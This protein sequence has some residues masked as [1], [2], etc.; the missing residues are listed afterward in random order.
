MKYAPRKVFII[1]NGEYVE[2][3]YEEFKSR[4]ETDESYEDKLFLPVQGCL[5]ETDR[6]HYQEFYQ[7]KEH[8][9]YL[10]KL[11]K[12]N[13]LLSIDAFD[14]E[15]DNGTDYIQDYQEDVADTVSMSLMKERLL[16]CLAGLSNEERELIELHFFRNVSQ[17]DIAK[18]MQKNQSTISRKIKGIL[19]NLKKILEN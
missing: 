9:L 4:K 2:L 16:Q 12:K 18:M 13:G 19:K 17:V 5:L 3:A 10:K 14:S 1:E 11:D 7:V 8:N 15:D 6:Q